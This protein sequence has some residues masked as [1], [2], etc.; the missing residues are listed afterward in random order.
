MLDILQ[1]IRI[2]M[3]M[4]VSLFMD[5]VIITLIGMEPIIIHAQLPTDMGYITILILVGDSLQVLVTDGFLCHF[6]RIQ[7]IGGHVVTVMD[8][9][10]DMVMVIIEDIIMVIVQVMHEV[11]TTLEICIKVVRQFALQLAATE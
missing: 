5:Q 1:A 2:P 3:Y 10:M 11:V 9:V 6:T 7:C 8:I 4:E